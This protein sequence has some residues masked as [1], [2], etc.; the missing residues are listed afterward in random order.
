MNGTAPHVVWT[1]HAEHRLAGF[2]QQ[3]TGADIDLESH[4]TD[5]Q[6]RLAAA[7]HDADDLIILDLF[8]GFR[9]RLGE[10][11]LLVDIHEPA[12]PGTFI[13]KLADEA[14]L[15]RERKAWIPGRLRHF[16]DAVFMKQWR[17]P[18]N[19]KDERLVALVY[20]HAE[21]HIRSDRHVFLEDAFLQSVRFNAVDGL[22]LRGVLVDLFH[23]LGTVL[24]QNA[25]R[26]QEPAAGSA[27]RTRTGKRS[28]TAPAGIELNW[29][30]ETESRR[31]LRYSLDAWPDSGDL[32]KFRKQVN[33][34]FAHNY[35]GYLDPI[36]FFRFVDDR[37]RGSASAPDWVPA[38]LRGPAH[39]DLHGR[40][41]L[42]GIRAKDDH[43]VMPALFDYEHMAADNLIGWDF[44][45]LE[46]EL[47][48]RAYHHL[49]GGRGRQHF[50]CDAEAF[51]Q[52]LA[53]QC[54]A[55]RHRGDLPAFQ[56]AEPRVRLM[57][58]LLLIRHLAG[59]WLKSE[60]WLTNYYFLLGS[61]GVSTGSYVN[62]EPDE[63]LGT[64]V[65]AGVAA[66]C[67][68]SR[69]LGYDL[70]K[71]S[72]TAGAPRAGKAILGARRPCPSYREPLQV[73][74]AWN[75]SGN[76]DKL[77]RGNTLLRHLR[78]RYPH[79]LHVWCESA[80]GLVK[81]QRADEALA[82]LKEIEDQFHEMLDEDTLSLGARC[83]KDRGD[84]HRAEG[85]RFKKG[86]PQRVA[87]FTE[88][89]R[90]YNE[91]CTRYEQAYRLNANWFPGINLATLHLLRAAV[92]HDLG[93]PQEAELLAGSRRLAEELLAAAERWQPRLKDDN[94]W[95]AATRGEACLL[96]RNWEAAAS[97]Y[98]TSLK[99]VNCEPDHPKT[100]KDQVFRIADA[101]SL[102]GVKLGPPF[103]D[104]DAFFNAP[105]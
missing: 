62:Q 65:S 6:A 52:E 4:R 75:R 59:Q 68:A 21:G 37:V 36:D 76:P 89:D 72:A 5:I 42:V 88:A 66:A 82:L 84:E 18:R 46:T 3:A 73:A 45:K 91:A 30:N 43:V 104:P 71:A 47:K 67:F 102:L 19:E 69:R 55:R 97:W 16:D 9:P 58:L 57:S 11:V 41:V 15:R 83:A 38:L 85:L 2:L 28:G 74:W 39:G 77:A 63:R 100:M 40:N 70:T 25:H 8:Y 60:E 34:A 13:V 86:R 35:D 90:A 96:C 53:S 92:A 33:A 50:V 78:D 101:Y 32:A 23:H 31:T 94:I 14:R 10:Y 49:F 81:Q 79:A 64:L 51:E 7:F 87:A 44:V 22:S 105:A 20:Q 48:I 99:Q 12:H 17:L 54:E 95:I 93:W 26:L 56:G 29:D 27:S 61:Y 98:L 103:D 24:Y 1:H 80:F